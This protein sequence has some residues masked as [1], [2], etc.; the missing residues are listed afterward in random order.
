MNSQW[1][2]E[3]FLMI[4]QQKRKNVFP[5]ATSSYMQV[6]LQHCSLCVFITIMSFNSSVTP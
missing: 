5:T 6:D 4:I 1:L 3:M 2:L